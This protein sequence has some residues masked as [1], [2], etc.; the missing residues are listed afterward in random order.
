MDPQLLLRERTCVLVGPLTSIFQ[1]LSLTLSQLGADIAFIDKDTKVAQRF[2]NQIMDQREVNDKFGRSVALQFDVTKPDQAKEAISRAAET[3]GTV[4]IVIDGLLTNTASPFKI[5]QPAEE[6][7]QLIDQSLKPSLYV[8]QAAVN[9]L[10]ARKRGRLIY[11]THESHLTGQPVDA[12]TAA[13]RGGLTYFAQSIAKEMIDHTLTV[14]MISMGLTEEYLLGHFPECT[15]IKDAFEKM[16]AKN[17]FAKITEPD[18]VSQAIMFLAGPSGSSIT[19]QV[20][21]TV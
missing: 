16:K 1:N 11:L 15:T 6:I 8:A 7:S 17:P 18:K 14:N 2:A 13:V 20:I 10:K 4:D 19:G 21:R 12:L 9:F 3:F 5:D